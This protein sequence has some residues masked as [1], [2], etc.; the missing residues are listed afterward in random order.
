MAP[1]VV[2][3]DLAEKRI[4]KPI[5]VLG[6]GH[7]E[8]QIAAAAARGELKNLA[9]EGKPLPAHPEEALADPG[10][11]IGFRIM[12]EAGA[13]PE[14]IKLRKSLDMARAAYAELTDPQEKK[15]AMKIIA[16]LMMRHNIAQEA[17]KK[18]MR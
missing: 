1:A 18:F 13:L 5:A 11:L 16:D 15:A 17:R 14:E 4:P 9:G 12:A 10:T 3:I 7:V 2:H 6:A 8:Q